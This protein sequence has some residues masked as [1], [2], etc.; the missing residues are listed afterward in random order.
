M[1]R[2]RR[3]LVLSLLLLGGCRGGPVQQ[4]TD[5]VLLEMATHPFDPAPPTSSE[6]KSKTP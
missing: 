3:L 2:T 5:R 1:S 4:E 6:D